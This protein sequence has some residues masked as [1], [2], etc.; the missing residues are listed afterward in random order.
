MREE[1][2]CS[3]REPHRQQFHTPPGD[4]RSYRSSSQNPSSSS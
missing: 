1:N 4:G 3:R 2:R